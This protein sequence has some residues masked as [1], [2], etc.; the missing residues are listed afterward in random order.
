MNATDA[1]ARLQTLAQPE[2]LEG[3]SRYGIQTGTALGVSM[4]DVRKVARQIGRNHELALALWDSGIHEARILAGLVEIPDR[5]TPAQM[6]RWTKQFD[7]WDLCDQ[8]CMNLY[9]KTPFAHQ[10]AAAWSKAK[11]E[12][13]KRAGFALMA[14]LAVHD[15]KSGDEPLAL[16]LPM[17]EREAGDERNFVKKAV[18]WALRQIGKRNRALNRAAVATAEKIARQPSKGARWVAADALRE[19]TNEKVQARLASK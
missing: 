2:K 15:K 18:N 6:E 1:I 11:R 4:P 17:I 3:M 12:F 9:S 14:V 13:V 5:V 19:L 16:F 7:S 8:T 10:K